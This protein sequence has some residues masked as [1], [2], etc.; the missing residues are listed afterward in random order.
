MIPPPVTGDH[1]DSR[2]RYSRGENRDALLI[3]E[4]PVARDDL[5]SRVRDYIAAL[6]GNTREILILHYLDEN[7]HEE[8]AG[9]LNISPGAVRQRLHDARKK[10]KPSLGNLLEGAIRRPSPPQHE[11]IGELKMSDRKETSTQPIYPQRTAE[12]IIAGMIKPVSCEHTEA[13][14]ITW[15][16]FCAAIRNDV[17]T[18]KRH[19]AEDPERARL[20]FWYTPPIHFAVREGNLEATR[21]L[22]EA[23]PYDEVTKLIHMSD[24]RD[25]EAVAN[26]LREQIGAG[27]FE[28]DRRLHEAVESRDMEELVRLLTEEAAPTEQRDPAGRTPLHTAVIYQQKEAAERLLDADASVDATDHQGFRPI[29]YA[30]W[31]LTYWGARVDDKAGLARLLMERGAADSITLA[32]ARGDI[33]AVR[34]F[35]N[36][37]RAAA[38]DG[39]TL[40]K[41]PLST[42]VEGGHRDMVRLLLNHGADPTRAET[43]TCPNGSALMTAT[44]NGHLELAQMLIDAGADPNGGIDS[45]GWPASRAESD[46]MR[47]LLYSY[48]G[49]PNPIWGYIQKGQIEIVAAILRYTDDPFAQETSEYLT[50]PYTSIIS[51]WSR[52]KD[53]NGPTEAYEGMLRLFLQRNYPMP[54]VLTECRTYLWHVPAMTRQLLERGL[55]PNLPD[56]QRRTPMH[57]FASNANPEDIQFE[58]MGMFLDHGADINIVDEEDRSTPLGIAAGNGDKRMVQYLLDH[59]AEPNKAGAVWATPLAWAEKRGHGEVVEMLRKHGATG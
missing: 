46:T 27:V 20:E 40:Q 28:A 53:K 26:Y 7:S 55:D 8:I 49:K 22:W 23:Y 44:V 13:G 19:I 15:E 4:F 34:V 11:R 41:R 43:R 50:T 42:A 57:D 36:K 45:S 47:T 17:E 18:L 51:G 32:A 37:D 31:N 21:V 38:N 33:D 24:N 58:L 12:E 52:S 48:G 16:M 5:N 59:G 25:Y 35:L 39:D 9:F 29:H 14:R 2:L 6:P 56:W 10:I 3:R 54:K 30:Y 1:A